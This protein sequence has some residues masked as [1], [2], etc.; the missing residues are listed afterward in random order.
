MPDF[1]RRVV[2]LPHSFVL[3]MRAVLI[4]VPAVLA[5]IAWTAFEVE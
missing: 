1:C 4:A 5:P 2:P 3:L